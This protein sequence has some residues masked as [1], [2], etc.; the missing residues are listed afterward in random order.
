MKKS[1]FKQAYN[2][3]GKPSYSHEK[4]KAASGVYLIKSNKTGKIT[5]VGESGVHIYKTMYRHFQTWNDKSQLRIVYPKK[6]YSIRV[7]LCA[8]AQAKKLEQ[9][10]I[11]KY[12]P[13]DNTLKLDLFLSEKQAENIVQKYEKQPIINVSDFED[14]PF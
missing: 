7:V 11:L 1:R 8:P 6:G 14:P 13:K 10:L 4:L 12:R 2:A 3:Q 9:A 5:Y